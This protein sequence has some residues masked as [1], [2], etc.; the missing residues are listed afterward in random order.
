ME[1]QPG[2]KR[3]IPGSFP[4]IPPE[5]GNNNNS[6]NNTLFDTVKIYVQKKRIR[7]FISPGCF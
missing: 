7:K 2:I 4:L 5:I 3:K 6:N 1:T